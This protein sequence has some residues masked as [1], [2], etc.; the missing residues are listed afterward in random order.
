LVG[1]RGE[2][3]LV[4]VVVEV[5]V[6]VETE[7][8]SGVADVL[9]DRRES[10]GRKTSESRGR[11]RKRAAGHRKSRSGRDGSSDRGTSDQ[12]ALV[13]HSAFQLRELVTEVMW[14]GGKGD[15]RPG[16]RESKRWGS[17]S[18]KVKRGDGEGGRRQEWSRT[19]EIGLDLGGVLLITG[20]VVVDRGRG[21]GRGG[22]CE[23]GVG[24]DGG[25][26]PEVRGGVSGG[27]GVVDGGRDRAGVQFQLD[28]F[29]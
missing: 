28:G 25:G 22:G 27:D 8:T 19:V 15:W 16:G 24:L 9:G 13:V 21:T 26:V 11:K 17:V 1:V 10:G 2:V 23:G 3:L 6:R 12:S 5:A 14:S 20:V 7:G 4:V 18:R 29:R